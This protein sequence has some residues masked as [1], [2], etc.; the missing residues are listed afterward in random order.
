MIINNWCPKCGHFQSIAYIEIFEYAIL[1]SLVRMAKTCDN[2]GFKNFD[3]DTI[4][5]IIR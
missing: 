1:C 4:E 3:N 5:N 2:C